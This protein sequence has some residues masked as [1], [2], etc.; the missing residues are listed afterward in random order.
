MCQIPQRTQVEICVVARR[1]I[2][3]EPYPKAVHKCRP[4]SGFTAQVG[5]Y[6]TN[7]HILN[8]LGMELFRQICF[9]KGIILG[10]LDHRGPR[11]L[12]LG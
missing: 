4:G 3:S 6:P 12:Q 10:F 8:L 5:H 9:E 11:Q 1:A 2:Y 7:D